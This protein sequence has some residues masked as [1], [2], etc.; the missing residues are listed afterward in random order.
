MPMDERLLALL[1]QGAAGGGVTP[2]TAVAG[3]TPAMPG[4]LP[5]VQNG[6]PGGSPAAGG[7][8]GALGGMPGAL[9]ALGGEGALLG[10]TTAMPAMPG[11]GMMA[12]PGDLAAVAGGVTPS[13]MAG[14]ADSEEKDRRKKR[15]AKRRGPD[16]EQ[17]DAAQEKHVGEGG[18][19][20]GGAADED[21][22]RA[23]READP[24]CVWAQYEKARL[25][26]NAIDLYS[27]VEKNEDFYIGNQWRGVNAPDLDKPVLNILARVVKFFIS[28]IVSDDIG[29]SVTD[30]AEDERAKPVMDMLAE[31][32]DTVMELT[33]FRK[34]TREVIRNAA[35]DG[36]GCMHYYFDPE[37]GSAQ[38]MGGTPGEIEAE[39][40]EN[41]NVHFGNPQVADVEKQPYILLN[42]R[43][44]VG[45]VRRPAEQPAAEEPDE[46]EDTSGD[47][48]DEGK[49]TVIRKYWKRRGRDGRRTVW[50]CDV[51]R[52]A[53]V[54]GATDTGMERYPIAFMAWEKVKNQFH[55]QAAITGMIPNQIFINKLMAMAMQ[56]V[57]AAAFPKVVY[58]R[59][60]IPTGWSNRVGEAIPVNG[61]PNV[62]VASGY[63]A[64]DMSAQ[65]LQMLDA[66]VNYTRD[67][68]G[69]SDAALGNIKP[70]N[71]SA[72]VATQQATSM[73]LELQKQD[74]YSFVE[75]SV[76]IWLDMMATYYGVRA[77]RLQIERPQ[78]AEAAGMAAAG[79]AGLP[80]AAGLA[81]AGGMAAP[82]AS[83][84]AAGTEDADEKQTVL[85]D[86]A[87]LRGMNLHLNVEI[88]A[89]TY[90]SELMQVQTLDNLFASGVLQDAVTYL[91]AMPSGYIP[92]KAS[93]IKSIKEQQQKAAAASAAAPASGAD[94]LKSAVASAVR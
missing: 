15:G 60:L 39:I 36:D 35:V 47:A 32:C 52:G 90:W 25:F 21:M 19:G 84:G 73:P 94:M 81:G 86:F 59:M 74:F 45:D 41:T 31:K 42:F 92:G 72:I 44:L 24:A 51:T 22:Q 14:A 37:A 78:V 57:K 2:G 61:D 10:A 56:H 65:V 40:I 1:A 70:D 17:R 3:V 6:L 69:A 12:M 50:F 33:D 28:S 77:V 80:V 88:G 55:G 46:D 29:V 48:P 76:R 71:T 26:N 87:R 54:R 23:Q 4:A 30:F 9:P 53:V 43:R 63:R 8:M 34:K 93:L 58:N 89:A 20:A 68:M 5:T 91:E 27:N 38:P 79:A 82:A 11:G 49:V 13:G 75:A 83:M 67:T 18:S 7:A 66:V 62:A 64:P 85:F 16:G